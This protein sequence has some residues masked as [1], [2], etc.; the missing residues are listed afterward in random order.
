MLQFLVA[1]PQK[2][3]R[4]PGKG[5]SLFRPDSGCRKLWDLSEPFT[6]LTVET[7]DSTSTAL[8]SMVHHLLSFFFAVLRDSHLSQATDRDKDLTQG[9]MEADGPGV[10]VSLLCYSPL[11]TV[12]EPGQS[13]GLLGPRQVGRRWEFSF[14]LL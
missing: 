5:P 10:S 1:G 12:P 7:M 8:S 9:Q 4:A 2:A 11:E 14:S 6:S 13:K 3:V